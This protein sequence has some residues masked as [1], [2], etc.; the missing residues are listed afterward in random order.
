MDKHLSDLIFHA[1]GMAVPQWKIL[2]S[3]TTSTSPFTL[4]VVVKPKGS[5]SSVDI[6]IATTMA[7]YRRAVRAVIN[8]Y[9]QAMVQQYVRGR[10]ITCGVLEDGRGNAFSL[11][12]TEIIPR[13]SSWFDY[14][15]KYQTGASQEITPAR[16]S[17]SQTASIQRLAK[18]AHHLL[19]CRGMSRSD[20]IFDGRRFWILELNTIPGLT[21]TSL[22]PQG[23]AAAGIKFPKVLDLIIAAALRRK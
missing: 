4:P 22:L 12:P 1:D 10:E 20:F 6:T 17:K 19:G 5:G 15:A 13:S 3:F 11:P 16:L 2:N 18:H 8:T 23:A 9:G 14:R 21:E 7:E